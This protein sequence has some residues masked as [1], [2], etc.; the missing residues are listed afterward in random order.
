MLANYETK[1]VSEL[2]DE[3]AQVKREQLIYNN[4]YP[5][6]GKYLQS[7]DDILDESEY[8]STL[9]SRLVYSK[10]SL[11]Y[12]ASKKL[13]DDW[14]Q[15]IFDMEANIK[16][17]DLQCPPILGFEAKL[18]PQEAPQWS[19]GHAIADPRIYDPA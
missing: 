19:L 10:L 16:N 5:S 3:L 1:L 2:E 6:H 18:G 15:D 7:F 9:K 17:P 12:Y 11:L 14:A 8:S 13:G 4:K